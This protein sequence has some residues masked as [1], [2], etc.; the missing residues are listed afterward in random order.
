MSRSVGQLLE[1]SRQQRERAVAID[2]ENAH[3]FAVALFAVRE[4]T[5]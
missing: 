5:N 3:D 1:S 4:R 2:F